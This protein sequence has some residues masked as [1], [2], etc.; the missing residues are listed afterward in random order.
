[1]PEA[2][3]QDAFSRT[4]LHGVDQAANPKQN[5]SQGSGPNLTICSGSQSGVC[6]G[7]EIPRSSML[8]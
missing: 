8:T 5:V 1:M 6:S 4:S 3:P 7:S 2:S